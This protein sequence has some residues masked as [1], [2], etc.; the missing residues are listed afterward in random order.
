MTQCLGSWLSL[1]GL[2]LTR[3]KSLGISQEHKHEPTQLLPLEWAKR[4]FSLGWFF[5]FLLP[6]PAESILG[7]GL[8]VSLGH[9][10]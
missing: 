10:C 5:L 3:T 8:G 2:D 1:G 4:H 7:S 9:V 6:S